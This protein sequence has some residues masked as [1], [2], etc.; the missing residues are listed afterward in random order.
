MNKTVVLAGCSGFAGA[1]LVKR[2]LQ[3]EYKV[4]GID[5]LAFMEADKLDESV[6]NNPNFTYLW[7]GLD[8]IQPRHIPEG[9][10]VV[11]LAAYADV[12]FGLSSPKECVRNNIM[13]TVSLLEAVKEVKIDRFI[14]ASSGNVFG[15]PLYIPID[16]KHP[17]TSHNPYSF[18]KAAQEMACWAWWRAYNVP[19]VIMSNGI[20]CGPGM[21][22]DI[23]IYR[24]LYNILKDRPIIIEGEPIADQTRDITF[25]SD[26]LDAWMLTIEYPRESVVGEK[27]Q[28]SYGQEMKVEDIAELCMDVCNHRVPIIRKPHRPGEKGQREC[29]DTRKAARVLGYDPKVGPRAAIR[30]TVPWVKKQIDLESR[31][32]D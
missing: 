23:V 5:L 7:K 3:K 13:S 29:F 28:V 14:F 20:V 26:V 12:P 25:V 21:R 10:I 9:S 6:K 2:L 18:S 17:T 16:E 15:R 22:R 30:L 24:W 11:D 31:Y 4:I 1:G 19:I 8:D 27:F 32:T